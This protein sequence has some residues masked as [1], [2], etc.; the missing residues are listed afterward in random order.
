VNY[1]IPAITLLFVLPRATH[2]Q[3]DLSQIDIRLPSLEDPALRANIGP[4]SVAATLGS[5]GLDLRVDDR[6][7]VE[8]ASRRT[9]RVPEDGGTGRAPTTTGRAPTTTSRGGSR[10]GASASAAAVLNTA[11]DHLGVPYVWG[12]TTPRGFDCSGFV[13]YVYRQHG[14]ELPRTS[15]QQA[16]V[17]MAI[18]ATVSE[19][20]AG[21]LMFFATNGK[22]IDHV[23]IYAGNNEIIHS[24]ASGG[25]VGYDNLSSSRGVWFVDHHVAT[26]RVLAN[27]I[28]LVGNLTAALRTFTRLDLDPPDHAPR[29]R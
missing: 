15:R 10:A 27:G 23:A 11:E 7:T 20:R 18:G 29:R 9:S 8:R 5:R 22:R 24:S 16:V 19:L 1:V 6:A 28:N 3:I 4:W 25:G 26:R 2:A 17:G 13:Q 14:V 21:D 12:G